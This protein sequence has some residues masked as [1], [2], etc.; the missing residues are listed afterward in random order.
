MGG[1]AAATLIILLLLPVFYSIF[2]LDLKWSKWE[3]TE[4]QEKTADP[5]SNRM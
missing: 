2:V 1:L 5:L 3:G 4:D